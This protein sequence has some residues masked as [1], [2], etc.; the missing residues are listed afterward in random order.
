MSHGGVSVGVVS[1][2]G[3]SVR[4]MS[5]KC[6]RYESGWSECENNES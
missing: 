2:S 1:Q 5:H 4:T 3:V 6:E